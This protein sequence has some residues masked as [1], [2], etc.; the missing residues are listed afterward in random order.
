MGT[1]LAW[2][3]RPRG[4]CTGYGPGAGV[5]HPAPGR[6]HRAAGVGLVLRPPC[7]LQSRPAALLRHPCYLSGYQTTLALGP[8]YESP[9][10]HTTP[11]LSLPQNLT[12]EGTGNPGA[13]VSA[14][15]ELFNF[16]SCQGQED[17]A[18]DGVYQ[19]PLRGQFYVSTHTAPTR[20][21]GF[22]V[23]PQVTV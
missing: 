19:P 6:G 20:G 5:G 13:C 12:V 22:L 7:P 10:V 1:G 17:C 21:P 14:I 18:F 3:I 9:C 11:P 15:R 23:R 2:V 8:L 16:S 4:G